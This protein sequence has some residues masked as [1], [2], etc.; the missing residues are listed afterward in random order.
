MLGRVA[1]AHGRQGELR[2][3]VLGDAPDHLMAL[4][5]VWLGAGPDDN[6][7][8]PV[9]VTGVAAGRPGE[10]RMGLAG[11]SDRE[12]ALALGGL[13]VL[14]DAAALPPLP[15]GEHYWY[16]LVGCRVEGDDGTRVGRVREI[17]E[18]G[19]HDV[20]VV[21]G[22][23]GRTRLLPTAEPLLEEVDVAGRRIVIR[24]IPGLLDP[25]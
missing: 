8:R 19:A 3:Q 12:S 14:G 1:G 2:V 23:D 22:E 7:A 21:E 15:T 11:I 17:W 18:T 6:A 24:V 13:L 10:L 16:E 25:A 4:R 20:L 5:Q 9:E